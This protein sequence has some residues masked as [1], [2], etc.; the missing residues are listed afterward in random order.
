MS[1]VDESEKIGNFALYNMP[2]TLTTVTAMVISELIAKCTKSTGH[3]TSGHSIPFWNLNTMF[4]LSLLL[5]AVISVVDNEH[6]N[7]RK[8]GVILLNTFGLIF[9]LLTNPKVSV[10]LEPLDTLES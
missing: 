5:F 4:L 10:C 9:L 3:V 8:N 1:G 7:M 6:V 2:A